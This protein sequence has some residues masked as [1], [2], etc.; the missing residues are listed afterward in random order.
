MAIYKN[1]TDLQN[2]CKAGQIAGLVCDELMVAA[3][4]G[5]STMALEAMANKLLQMNRSTQPFKNFEG[6]THAICI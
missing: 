3:Q 5:I 1:R 2:L 6:F 4:P